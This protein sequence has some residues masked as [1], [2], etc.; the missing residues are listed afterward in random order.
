MSGSNDALTGLVNRQ[1]FHSE[2]AGAIR[3]VP[4]EQIVVLYLDLDNFKEVDDT[5]GHSAGDRVLLEV[6]HRLRSCAADTDFVS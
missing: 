5:L 6:A 4:Q 2:L 3:Q 1:V